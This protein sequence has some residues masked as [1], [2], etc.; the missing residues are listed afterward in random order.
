M[1][2][3]SHHCS[4]ILDPRCKGPIFGQKGPGNHKNNEKGVP[5]L[6]VSTKE[7]LNFEK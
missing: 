5:N 3:A 1:Y 6:Y 7:D 4:G 2:D